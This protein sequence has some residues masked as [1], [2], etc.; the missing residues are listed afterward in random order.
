MGSEWARKAARF[1]AV[2]DDPTVVAFDR[3]AAELRRWNEKV[4]LTAIVEPCAVEQ[5]HFLDS[6][7]CLLAMDDLLARTPNGPVIDVGSGGGFP[8]LPLKLARPSLHLTLLE[9][10]RKK[11][12]FLEH[13]VST[14]RLSDARV[15][16]ARAEVAA[17][18]PA[19]RERYLIA[20]A[21]ALAP[22]P[23]L[24]ELCLP[25]V[26]PGGR[27]V[28]PRRGDLALEL[29]AAAVAIHELGGE[30][31][32]VVP[33]LLGPEDSGRGLVVIEKVRPSAERYP[34]RDGVPSKRP[35]G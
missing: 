1:G 23:A 25:F 18:D 30:A 21:R 7:S 28:A 19:H 4:N 3:L 32:P 33:V 16:T 10:A 31:R 8:G 6:L 15:V 5:R 35:L 11:T 2:L 13:V 14:L 12:R 26:R 9:S 24:V 20:V 17:R 22:L 27:L 29:H 34:R